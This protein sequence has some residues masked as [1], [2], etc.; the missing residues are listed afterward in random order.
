MRKILLFAGFVAILIA[1]IAFAADVPI[2]ITPFGGVEQGQTAFITVSTTDMLTN[3]VFMF[4]GKKYRLFK[5][6]ENQYSGLLGI[7][8]TEKFGKHEMIVSD[9]TK[10]I[11]KTVINVLPKTYPRQNIRVSSSMSSLEPTNDEQRQ[12]CKAKATISDEKYRTDA[13]YKSPTNG[14]I[15]SVY[16]LK[17]YYNGKVSGAYHKG[18]DI[19]AAKGTPVYTITDGKVLI[20]SPFRLNGTTVAVDHGQG[21]V[22][23]YLHLSKL[24]VKPGEFVKAG[25]KIGEVG[26]TG[27]ATGPHLHWGLYIN[28]TPI[29]PMAGWIKPVNF[30]K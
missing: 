9:G 10:I 11:G 3:P 26:S 25:Q 16:G 15:A 4:K 28:G 2:A 14:C 20:A 13:P 19:K 5:S 1:K 30:C 12:I 7:E 18:I 22:S 21:L 24:D 17:R 27:F 29:D 23:F 6:G 8:A